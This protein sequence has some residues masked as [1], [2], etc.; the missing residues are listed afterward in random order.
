MDII[1]SGGGGGGSP[2][3]PVEA[4]DTLQ[5]RQRV[6]L[7]FAVSEGEISALDDILLNNVP[8][9]NFD[10]TFEFRSG[11]VGQSVIPG[12]I[13]TEQPVPSFAPVNIV[14]GT[15]YFASLAYDNTSCRITLTL[16]GLKEVLANGDTIGYRVDFALSTR[17]STSSIWTQIATITKTGKASSAY[18]WDTIVPAPAGVTIASNWEIKLV[19]TTPTDTSKQVSTASWASAIAITES[20][21]TYD[22]TAL[23]GIT[24]NDA[25]QFGGNIPE[26]TFKLKG[27]KVKIPTNYD[28]VT[29]LY[30]ETVPWDLSL[31]EGLFHYTANPAWHIYMVLNASR[32]GLNITKADID[33]VSLYELSKYCDEL[34]SDGKG[35]Q[36]RRYELHNQFYTREEPSVL[37]M[38][39][40]TICNAN[41]T[42]NEFGQISIMFDRPGQAVTKQITNANIIDGE[43]SYS[44]AEIN[45]RYNLVNVTYNRAEFN[46]KTDTANATEP[47]LVSR[48][49]LQTSD[50]VLAGCISEAQAVRKA[51]WAIYTSSYLPNIISFKTLFAGLNYHVGE[52]ARVFD[53]KNQGDNVAGLLVSSSQ[54]AGVTT[55]QLD[56]TVTLTNDPYTVYFL[57]LDGI[58]EKS[59]SI[60]E[61]NTT[62]STVNFLSLATPAVNSTFILTGAVKDRVFKVIKITKNEDIYEL[63]VAEHKEEKY[64]YID[65]AITVAQPTG[66]FIDIGEF[67]TV[68]VTGI[69]VVEN[70]SSNGVTQNSTLDITWDW[71]KGTLKYSAG[72][73]LTWRRDSQESN[74]IKELFGT[75]YSIPNPVPGLYEIT[76]WAVNPVSGIRSTPF[77]STYN[78][79]SSSGTSSLQPP[80]NVFVA[81]TSGLTFKTKDL[82]LTFT[83]D[84]ANANVSDTLLD[85]VIEVWDASASTQKGDYSVKPDT[86]RGGSFSFPFTENIDRFGT[87][88]R[89]FVLKVFSRDVIGDL[90]LPVQVTVTNPVPAAVSFS[91]ISGSEASYLNIA[92]STDTDLAGYLVY[93]DTATFTPSPATLLS[94]GLDTS[95]TLSGVSGQQYFYNVAAYD[96]FGKTGLNFS[97]EQ[98]STMLTS[99]VD[100]WVFEGLIFKPNNPVANKVSWTAGSASKNGATPVAITAGSSATAWTTGIQYFYY[101]GTSGTI[102]VTTD[103]AVAVNGVQVLATYKGGTSLVVGNGDAYTDG[104]L[105]LANT[106]GAN[107]LVANSA[108]ITN[109]AQLATAVISSAAIADAAI[110]NVKIGN[111]IQSSNFNATTNTGWKLDKAGNITS[112][113]T[114]S[115]FDTA[116]ATI[117]TTGANAAIEWAK[118]G[119][120]N[121]PADNA[122]VGAAIG[123]N[124]SGKFT[125]DNIGTYMPTAAIGTAQIQ[126]LAV[127][128][129]KIDNL[130]VD[131]LKI[132]GNA[133]AFN[134]HSGVN[135]LPITLSVNLNSWSSW[136]TIISLGIDLTGGTVNSNVS[137]IQ[138]SEV[139]MG[140]VPI[141]GNRFRLIDN[142]GTIINMTKSLNTSDIVH[143]QYSMF[144]ASLTTGITKTV[145]ITADLL[146]LGVKSSV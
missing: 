105:I 55:L 49:G 53:N 114:L 30:D 43:F 146:L 141:V 131:T 98:S 11:T 89:A 17:P 65:Q 135:S 37:L 70:F 84:P 64:T 62:T 126:D 94:D 59:Y 34:V 26:V 117:L 54:A 4:N 74:Y 88:T 3:T 28:P 85:Y 42:S 75:T 90:S 12:F 118:V 68:P 57:D 104:G 134:L 106:V 5:S 145:Y 123:S 110:T 109:T 46:G 51:R 103:I 129:G 138:V 127:T 27:L 45:S 116:G 22:N 133:V 93:R 69:T 111:T 35:G 31:T 143:L 137:A 73:A 8:I 61:T 20:N 122:T 139:D 86:S 100:T 144:N 50:I 132:A 81:G 39:L 9:T 125:A 140:G 6:K 82:N 14:T 130:A 87:A 66:D 124:L 120:L 78:F 136:V 58:T 102:S 16:N 72:F 77:T 101:D 44:S 96:T 38:H 142:A 52:L 60:V 99:T 23:V 95:V 48:Y 79:R 21:L 25:D 91:I 108:I 47:A 76:V 10:A 113:G 36:E 7:L 121:K 13:D 18:S 107:Q 119:G 24:L 67:L 1:G 97:G 92:S 33:V 63:D 19:R 15:E 40:L 80:Q 71:V 29:H 83:Y 2:H 112:Y 115:L 128:T 32:Y 41:F 56:R